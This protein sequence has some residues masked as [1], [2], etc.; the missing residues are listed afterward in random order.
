M[1]SLGLGRIA[2]AMGAAAVLLA[3]CG[4]LQPT[5]RA[6]GVMP[7]N[8][9]Q[10]RPGSTGSATPRTSPLGNRRYHHTF[11]YARHQQLFKVPL[12]VTRIT[13]VARGAAG[14]S[15]PYS[16][17]RGGL[18]GRVYAEV[19]VQPGETLYVFVGGAGSE[20]FGHARAGFNGG[21]EPGDRYSFASGGGGASDVRQ[22]GARLSDRILVAGGGGGQGAYDNGGGPGGAGGP[23]TGGAGGD[24]PS[25]GGGGGA[26]GGQTAGGQGGPGGYA[27][28]HSPSEAGQS[29][30]L[31]VGGD[32]GDGN[33]YYQGSEEG[34]GAGGGGGGG[35]Y[36]GGGGGA[37][38]SGVYGCDGM[39]GGGAGGGSSYVEPKAIE[40]RE[41][42]GW[43]DA[44]GN[45][46]IVFSW[47]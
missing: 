8:Q 10:Q 33:A 2:F 35:Y 25:G 36:G 27:S 5:M 29:G 20:G 28:C 45:G 44:I 21:G 34:G 19:P 46:L 39:P 43:K 7:Q 42:R 14:G 12:G 18:G 13:V 40:W 30:T 9:L 47:Q 16:P 11:K 15:P 1:K 37:G 23:S 32:G 24:A 26:G 22:G 4:G 38:A 3:A 41:W 6:P 31:G 17:R